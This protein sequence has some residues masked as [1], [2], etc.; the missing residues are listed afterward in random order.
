VSYCIN[1]SCPQR[2]NSDN[3]ESCQACGSPLLINNRYRLIAP[4]RPLDEYDQ[5]E[6][7]EIEDLGVE[8]LQ[9]ETY[10][11]L[12]V[13]KTNSSTSVRLFQQ[14][15]ETLKKLNHP[16]IPRVELTDGYFTISL[17]RKLQPLHCLVMEKIQGENLENWVNKNGSISQ[18]QALTWLKQ[19]LEILE[20]LH[21]QQYLHRDIKPSNIMLRPTGQLVLIDF[22][23][24]RQIT[25]TFLFRLGMRPEDT[26]TG[27]LS[28]GYT[29]LEQIKGRAVPQSDLYALG[30]T[31][32][33][34]LTGKHPCELDE[35]PQT[36]NLIWREYAQQ[37][38]EPLADWIDYLMATSP[39]QRPP[40]ASF[41]LNRLEEGLFP[42]QIAQPAPPTL[43]WLI[44]LN[45]LIFCILL[46]SGG[47]WFQRQQNQW[48]VSPEKNSPAKT[49]KQLVIPQ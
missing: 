18:E 6:V 47:Q 9:G 4:L 17:P 31:F 35:D 32:V 48:Q 23:A 38:S 42:P 13:L 28:I 44:I 22:G 26:G 15:A 43:R 12:K 11:V 34:L 20:H 45:V 14:E 49:R 3:L 41:V 7:F 10:K 25:N 27:I 39:W 40:N 21:Q 29:A 5:A 36:G 2:Q 24:L 19:L 16:G 8:A 37:I 1:P 46:V 33:H 30:R